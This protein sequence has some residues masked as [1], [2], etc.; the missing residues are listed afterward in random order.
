FAQNNMATKLVLLLVICALVCTVKGRMMVQEKG[1]F[2]DRK[3]F[4][5]EAALVGGGVTVGA[6]A[7][8]GIGGGQG[9]VG[10]IR[11]GVGVGGV[12]VGARV[13]VGVGHGGAGGTGGVA[14]GGGI[15][16]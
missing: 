3:L 2:D 7:G 15:I 13:G 14:G 9:S 11:G 16:P 10:G 5:N 6:R 8:I 1:S 12:T 4:Y